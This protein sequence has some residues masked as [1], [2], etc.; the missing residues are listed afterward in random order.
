[1]AI[2]II[3]PSTR[4]RWLRLRQMDITASVIGALF[5]VHDF[6]S[7]YEVWASKTGRL[8]RMDQENDA[9]R[10]GR[11][12]E[13]VAVAIIREDHPEWQVEY[14][15]EDQ[16]YYRDTVRRLGATPDV[17]AQCPR[18][19]KGI[20]QIKSVEQSVFRRKWIDEDGNA[21]APL[22]IALQASLE[23]YLVGAQWAAVCPLVIGFGIEAPVID[24]PLDHLGGVIDA[25]TEKVAE[26]WL[27]VEEDRE[28]P[29]DYGR[30]AALIDRLY[31]VG[32][33]REEVDLTGNDRVP[34]IIEVIKEQRERAKAAEAEVARYEAEIKAAM[35]TAEVAH[36]MG[37]RTITWKTHTRRDPETGRK[38]VYRQL[39]LP[40]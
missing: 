1:L 36:I 30:D 40:K 14:S 29:V 6:I 10:R 25:M 31:A 15:T 4:E 34:G 24:I 32:D 39:R 23:A 11:L 13:P 28:P 17:I 22:W 8:P 18:R 35:G 26:F 5:G 20:I 27:M 16:I 2:E 9:M 19:G 21:E 38:S 12:L 3:N 37:G 33:A 7:P